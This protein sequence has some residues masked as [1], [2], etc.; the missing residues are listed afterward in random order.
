MRR[1]MD[2]ARRHDFPVAL[3]DHGRREDSA[4]GLNDELRAAA[5]FPTAQPP[6]PATREPP[7]ASEQALP[8]PEGFDGR[9]GGMTGVTSHWHPD[10]NET[11]RRAYRA[12]MG[13]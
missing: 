12:V 6:V 10:F 13:L 8:V 3:R 1:A 11:L 5:G 9:I 4:T 2:W 7:T